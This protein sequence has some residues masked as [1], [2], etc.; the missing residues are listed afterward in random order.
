MSLVIN[1]IC[2]ITYFIYFRM[3]KINTSSIEPDILLAAN[4]KGT[5]CTDDTPRLC[6]LNNKELTH[7]R[8]K[9]KYDKYCD[10]N[11]HFEPLNV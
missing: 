9:I 11:L 10:L 6:Q 4:S 5:V 2:I 8:Y 1:S 3:K 7:M